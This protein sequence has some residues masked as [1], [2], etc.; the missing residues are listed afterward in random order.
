[1]VHTKLNLLKVSFVILSVFALQVSSKIF[2][3][4]KDL[5]EYPG[6]SQTCKQFASGLPEKKIDQS[7]IE[8]TPRQN[9]LDD[10]KNNSYGQI[11][12]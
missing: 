9:Y 2:E 8:S 5:E 11:A 12:T 6:M 7:K 10:C 1:M 3:E 4:L